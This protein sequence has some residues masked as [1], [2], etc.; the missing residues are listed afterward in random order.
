ML[1]RNITE[2]STCIIEEEYADKLKKILKSNSGLPLRIKDK[3]I[4]FNDYTIGELRIGDLAINI[5]PRNPAFSLSSFFQ[6]LQFLDK[7]LLDNL[8]GFGF[9]N[10][11]S[12][13]NLKDISKSFCLILNRLLQFG[14]TGYYETKTSTGFNV[15]GDISF[16]NY[17]PQLIPYEGIPS[18]HINYTVN[19]ASNKIIKSAIQK[20]VSLE[21]PSVNAAKYQILRELENI[22]DEL[23]SIEE[24]EEVINTLFSVNPHYGIALELAKKI[25][26]DLK[27]EYKNGEIEWLAFLENS[28]DIFEKYIIKVLE[29]SL[30]VK[31]EKWTEPKQFAVLNTSDKTGVKLFSPDIIL[32]YDH[33]NNS[34]LAV[35]DVKNKTFEPTEK[36]ELSH[37]TS[38]NDIYQLMFYCRQLNTNLGGL[39]YPSSTDNDPIQMEIE[40]SEELTIVLFSVNMKD[41][42]KNRHEK[43]IREVT[44][45]ILN[46]S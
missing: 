41:T 45:Y 35:L 40:T 22:D 6:I 16:N 34:A 3:T 2:N 18:K 11:Q 36:K 37:L 29:V 44:Q 25:L 12:L 1:V 24:I 31:V 46:K 26:F 42:M 30:P 20:L 15:H 10:S 7:P 5:A 14:L 9:E 21:H 38:S 4:I 19:S 43:F 39:I 23:F 33:R 27:L 13:F 32:N 8:D 17:I 28:N